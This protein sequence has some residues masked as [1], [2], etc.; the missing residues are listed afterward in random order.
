[1]GEL[2]V[3]RLQLRVESIPSRPQAQAFSSLTP[4]NLPHPLET[5]TTISGLD[6]GAQVFSPAPERRQTLYNTHLTYSMPNPRI[7][8]KSQFCAAFLVPVVVALLTIVAAPRSTHAQQGSG[9]EQ[10][11]AAAGPEVS[12]APASKPDPKRAKEAYRQAL[13]AEQDQDWQTAYD[14]YAEAVSLAPN[15]RDY[16]LMR[17]V[18]KSRLVQIKMNMAERDAIAGRLDEALKELRSA[19]YLDPL[20]P[21][22]RARIAELKAAKPVPVREI[23]EPSLAG[24]TQ[25]EYQPV[26]RNFD[27]R[28]DTKGAYEE[29]A[30]QFG[31]DV[32]FDVDLSSLPVRFRVSGVD[33]PT[34]ARL[35]GDVTGT[36]WRPLSSHLFFVTDDTPQKRR[37]YEPS[38]V[39]TVLLPSSV[40]PDDMTELL[41][42]VREISGITRS[43][44]D[45]GSRTITLRAAPR[46][47]A[48][49]SDLIRELEQPAGELL[50]EFE[51]LEVDRNYARQLGIVPPQTSQVFSLNP[52]EIQ[53]VEQGGQSLV[54]VINQVF[55]L[56]SSLSGLSPTQIA[57]LLASNQLS[58]GSLIPPLVAFGGGD[59]TFLATMPGVTANFAEM[60]S[61]VKS[62]QRVLLRAEDGQPATFFVG[63]RIPVSLATFSASFSGTGANVPGVS[64]TNFPTANY[65]AGTKPAA[66]VAANFH[67]LT[68]SGTFDLAVANQGSGSISILQ[69]NGDGTFKTATTVQLPTGFSPTALATYDFNGD[70]H[71]DLVVTSTNASGQGGQVSILLG[72]GDGT[73][74]P[75]ITTNTGNLPV[76]VVVA[77]FHNGVAGSNIDVA[78]ANQA[79]NSISIFQINSDGTF[80]TSSSSPALLK[81]P[82]GFKPAGL[83][84]GTFTN[85]GHADL[86]VADEGN[87]TVSVFLGNGDGTFQNR[88]DYSTGNSPVFVAVGDFNADGISDLAVANNGAA[89]SANSG[90]TVSILLGQPNINDSTV[91]NGTFAPGSERDFPAGA[92]PTSIAVGDFNVDGLDDLAVTD[93]TDNAVSVLLNLGGGLFGPNFELPVDQAPV[94]IVAD[95]FNGDS[96]TDVATANQSSNDATVILNSSSFGGATSPLAGTPFPGVEYLDIG[97]KVKVTP[98]IHLDGDVTLQLNFD[99]SSLT[100]Q[101]YNSIPV[102]S[103]QSVD[104]TV[105]VKENQ[106]AILA[107]FMQS[108]ATNALNGLPGISQLPGIDWLSQNQNAQNQQTELLILV[109]PRLLRLAPRKDHVIYAGQGN[110]EGQVGGTSR[111]GFAPGGQFPTRARPATPNSRPAPQGQQPPPNQPAPQHQGQRER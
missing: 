85:S 20:N 55:G 48:V 19:S 89:T 43:N 7:E 29:L 101:S 99:N 72:N 44:L 90:N 33:F 79:D 76:S 50:L 25:L 106:S 45:I 17:E 16:F 40:S 30:R 46:A 92:G 3:N 27:Y 80:S 24:E 34:A 37:D 69:G 62:G 102:I 110:P 8:R 14:D 64:S 78:V 15:V 88:T 100:S 81:L 57:S 53:Q 59:T 21:I 104:Q 87:D 107:G 11:P 26:T 51:V 96:K 9:A 6:A 93:E 84:T 18:A 66:I 36:F 95:D 42:V 58:I 86:A 41:R 13:R 54:N 56:P 12:L 91:G 2:V 75:A 65:A 28:G 1:M 73:F 74:Q 22:V 70:G 49:A 71:E 98:R 52:Q 77:N 4:T 68:S 5:G 83:A 97:L 82:N 32:A 38:L 94:S 39:R 60:L 61:L 109:T 10:Q 31:V 47:I 35:L 67:D 63:D 111:G 23:A 103:N 105:R 108:Q